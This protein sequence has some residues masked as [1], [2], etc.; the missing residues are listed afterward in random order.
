VQALA[1]RHDHL[2]DLAATGHQVGQQAGR[3]IGQRTDLRPRGLGEAGDNPGIDRI[4][5]GALSKSV[6][7]VADL[8]RVDHDDRHAFARQ[9]GRYDG[10]VSAGRLEGDQTRRTAEPPAQFTKPLTIARHRPGLSRRQ[11]MNVQAI[12]R[13]VDADNGELFHGDPSLRKRARGPARATVRVHWN[14]RRATTLRNGF[15]HPWMRRSTLRHR[16]ED[17]TPRAHR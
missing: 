12:L 16:N 4:G 11:D 8:G 15:N 10:L 3:P 6:G 2:D 5:L 14:D 17:S 1:L 13:Y 7:E 9:G